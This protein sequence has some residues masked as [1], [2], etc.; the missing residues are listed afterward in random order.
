MDIDHNRGNRSNHYSI[1]AIILAVLILMSFPFVVRGEDNAPA[2]GTVS[3]EGT[4]PAEGIAPAE[5]T[6]P[7]EETVRGKIL[8]ITE[9]KEKENDLQYSGG[10]MKIIYQDIKVHILSGEHKGETVIAQNVIDERMVYNL[11]LK[12]GQEVITQIVE[13]NDGKVVNAYVTEIYRQTYLTYLLILFLFSLV[14]F[15]KVKGLKT[16]VTLAI[17]GLAILKLLLPGILAGYNPI[18]LTVGICAVITALSLF[19]ISGINRKSV[20]AI[21]GTTGGVLVAGM[22]AMIFGSLASLTGLGEQETQM[23][24]F[25][26]RENGFDFEGL[27]FTAIIIGALGAIMDIAM[28]ISSSLYEIETLKP[29]ITPK[30]LVRAG[31]NIGGDV[32]GTMSNTLI[33]AYVGASL[34]LLLL[35]MAHAIPFQQFINWDMISSE[36]VRALAG[37]IGII[38]TIPLTT[39]VATILR[40]KKKEKAER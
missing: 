1:L 40:K 4:A 24:A 10:E 3:T 33:L 29:E 16:I 6:A 22:I 26:P 5:G 8:D 25:I 31:M 19:I 14:V 37:S 12:V 38:L 32:M 9:N 27:L 18:L 34:P 21:I 28:S 39:I 15:G 17:T 36:V 35:F 23:L 13:D 20:A 30:E 7:A 2:E 11:K